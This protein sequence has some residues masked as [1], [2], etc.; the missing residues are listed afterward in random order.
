MMDS[1][2][3]LS[4]LQ[5]KKK[6]KDTLPSWAKLLLPISSCSRGDGCCKAFEGW[7]LW[8]GGDSSW[9]LLVLQPPK[10][11]AP[12]SCWNSCHCLRESP[13]RATHS[14]LFLDQSRLSHTC[15]WDFNPQFHLEIIILIIEK[16]T[17]P[18]PILKWEDCERRSGAR[19]TQRYEK[20][21]LL[22]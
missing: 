22:N 5:P 6:L 17:Q 1:L 8:G 3:C 9:E 11:K 10:Q 4:A 7:R 19:V 18:A 20:T 12:S 15:W 2:L 21:R 14:I 16:T 13:A